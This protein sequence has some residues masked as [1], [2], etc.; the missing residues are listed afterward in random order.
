[1][2]GRTCQNPERVSEP[3]AVAM[4][5]ATQLSL[6]SEPGAVAMGSITQVGCS[7]SGYK[8]LLVT[9]RAVS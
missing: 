5:S 6:V 1:M 3:G 9:P 2:P 7:M 4:G 8:R